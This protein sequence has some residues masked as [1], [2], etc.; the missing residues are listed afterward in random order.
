[1]RKVALFAFVTL[2]GIW[3]F[4]PR[5]EEKSTWNRLYIS[6]IIPFEDLEEIFVRN[7]GFL[8]SEQTIAFGRISKEKDLNAIFERLRNAGFD[9]IEETEEHIFCSQVNQRIPRRKTRRESE[10][11]IFYSQENPRGPDA[12]IF[13][14]ISKKMRVVVVYWFHL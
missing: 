5:A 1:M 6:R 4:F 2:L 8:Q 11:H 14:E 3:C 7:T 12:P 13:I 9:H 10:E